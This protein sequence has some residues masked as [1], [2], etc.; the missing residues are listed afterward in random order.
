MNTSDID[1][2]TATDLLEAAAALSKLLG[3]SELQLETLAAGNFESKI[4]QPKEKKVCF[5]DKEYILE[6]IETCTCCQTVQSKLFF[7][8]QLGQRPILQAIPISNKSQGTGE[9]KVEKYNVKTCSACPSN[10]E[11]LPKSEIIALYLELVQKEQA[12]KKETFSDLEA[13]F[14]ALHPEKRKK[15]TELEEN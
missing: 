15:Q 13:K 4:T 2:S 7:F 11:L 1:T 6:R 9:I 5:K 8:K 3:L 10:L 14:L 12:I